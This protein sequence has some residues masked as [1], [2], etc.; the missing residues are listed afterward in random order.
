LQKIFD[1]EGHECKGVIKAS[2]QTGEWFYVEPEVEGLPV[3][4]ATLVEGV[5]AELATG[6]QVRVRI[7][8]VDEGRGQLAM[9]L[10]GKL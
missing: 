7:A 9:D 6:D 5:N 4:V 8:G 10:L 1:L 3:G 2:S